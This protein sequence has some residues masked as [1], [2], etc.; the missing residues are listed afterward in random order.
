MKG[1][2]SSTDEKEATEETKTVSEKAEYDIYTFHPLVAELDRTLCSAWCHIP[3]KQAPNLLLLITCNEF[4]CVPQGRGRR[5]KGKEERSAKEKED[6]AP[7][8]LQIR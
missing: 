3:R 5:E 1:S 7:P 4:L 6:S 2:S 8:L